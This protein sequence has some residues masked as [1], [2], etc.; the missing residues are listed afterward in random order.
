MSKKKVMENSKWA[1]EIWV[2]KIKIC[3]E[4]GELFHLRPTSG[5]ITLVTTHESRKLNGISLAT[6]QSLNIALDKIIKSLQINDDLQNVLKE[7]NF[8]EEN[9]LE[10]IYQRN[11]INDI[12]KGNVMRES[13]NMSSLIFIAS[14]LIF[15]ENH[16]GNGRIDVLAY[17]DNS[18]YFIELKT[19][20]NIIDTPVTQLKNYINSYKNDPLFFELINTYPNSKKLNVNIKETKIIG[21]V[22]IGFSKN[23]TELITVDENIY[24]LDFNN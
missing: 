18:L 10:N 4:L 2:E 24:K 8:S 13:L 15:S 7:L 21:V 22:V 11:L 12:I 19:P 1:R 23:P 16:D 9:K 5:G 20:S 14:E 6:K 17:G 3:P